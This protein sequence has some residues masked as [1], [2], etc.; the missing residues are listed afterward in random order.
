MFHAL[1]SSVYACWPDCRHLRPFLMNGNSSGTSP[2]CKAESACWET[3]ILKSELPFASAAAGAKGRSADANGKVKPAKSDPPT[4]DQIPAVRASKAAA[5]SVAETPAITPEMQ[6][7]ADKHRS[8]QRRPRL[9]L[10]LQLLSSCPAA[11]LSRAPL[12][13]AFTCLQRHGA[14]A[15]AV[16]I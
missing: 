9:V 1:H 13:R 8:E 5:S 7:D 4:P 12:G 2:I 6:A 14:H 3:V 11:G 15:A 16:L 10:C